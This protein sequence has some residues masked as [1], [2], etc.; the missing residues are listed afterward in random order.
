MNNDHEENNEENKEIWSLLGYTIAS[1][2][3]L[4]LWGVGIYIVLH[5]AQ[6]Y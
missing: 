4:A 5:F 3:S 1:I 6:K 2:I